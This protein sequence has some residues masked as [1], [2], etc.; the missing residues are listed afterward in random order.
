MVRNGHYPS[1]INNLNQIDATSSLPKIQGD[2]VQVSE[3]LDQ[4][5][6][7]WEVLLLFLL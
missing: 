7:P 2:L 6:I 4:M 1:Y 5:R 3:E